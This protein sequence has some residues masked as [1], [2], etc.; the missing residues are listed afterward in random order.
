METNMDLIEDVCQH[1]AKLEDHYH[2]LGVGWLMSLL[3]GLE[4]HV[5]PFT[6]AQIVSE[7]RSEL[8]QIMDERGYGVVA[9]LDAGE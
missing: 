1:V 7:V 5:D 4:Q 6:Y 8:Q 9:G 2:G 3:R